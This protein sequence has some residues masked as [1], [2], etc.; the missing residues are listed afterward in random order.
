MRRVLV[1]EA[2][3][4]LRSDLLLGLRRHGI[5]AE[6]VDGLTEAASVL[7]TGRVDVVVVG[8]EPGAGRVRGVLQAVSASPSQADIVALVAGRTDS[9]S[10][11]EWDVGLAALKEGATDF[12]RLTP[13]IDTLALALALA[14]VKIEA[15][16]AFQATRDRAAGPVAGRPTDRPTGNA[17]GQGATRL[18]AGGQ[19]AV[20]LAPFVSPSAALV[21]EDPKIVTVLAMVRRL[22]GVRAGL[23]VGGES[24]TG[25][26][27]V[28]RALHDQSPWRD[29][30]FVAVNCGAISPGLI[31]SELFGHVRGS[32]T[33]AV[34]D[35]RGLFEAA[36]GGTLFLDEIADL[37]LGLQVKL[38][39]VLQ[40]GVIRRVGDV[41]DL[42]VE[43]RVV[44]ATARDL[45]A[46][47]RAGRFREDLYYRLAG[48]SIQI[49]P[50]R[51][52]TDD[53]PVLARHFL[54]RACHRLRL[55]LKEIEPEAVQ[56]LLD[57]AW[58]GNVRELENT[59]ER[60]VVLCSG[61]RIDAASLPE[62]VLASRKP[63]VPRRSEIADVA[64][65]ADLSIKK[66]SRRA[67][68]GLI[69]RALAET[70]GNRTR[71]A[72]LLEISHRALLYKI[73]EYKI[74]VT[75]N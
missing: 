65:P 38:L 27:L 33:D 50:L 6:A 39:R 48:L 14:L 57:H 1:L 10:G 2:N 66:A 24:G 22:A 70:G 5:D 9:G 68:Q 20:P 72:E 16:R 36:H 59:I 34:R 45:L 11:A 17:D 7:A 35:K 49:P 25:K 41:D 31:E 53:I 23:L 42:Q 8:T 26:E 51:E 56:L 44:A 43:V 60:A 29:G 19:G 58:P 15:R 46:E 64:D 55:P 12:V 75:R 28:A 40:D 73:K 13:G 63:G 69:R 71:A 37:A 52:R 61:E 47:V 74:V 30:P 62:R 4:T 32:F 21:G 3:E 67:E 18:G 54:A